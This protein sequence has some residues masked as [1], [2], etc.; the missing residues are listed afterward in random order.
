MQPEKIGSSRV[1]K[2]EPEVN[3]GLEDISV[4]RTDRKNG[5]PSVSSEQVIPPEQPFKVASADNVI[6]NGNEDQ[7]ITQIEKGIDFIELAGNLVPKTIDQLAK[8]LVAVEQWN[9]KIEKAESFEEAI[10][11]IAQTPP[12]LFHQIVMDPFQTIG[13]TIMEIEDMPLAK[14]AMPLTITRNALSVIKMVG[15]GAVLIAKKRLWNEA[16]DQL[17]KF[18]LELSKFPNNEDLKNNIKKLKILISTLEDEMKEKAV[19]FLESYASISLKTA[20]LLTSALTSLAPIVKTSLGWVVSTLDI[21]SESI[22]LWRA[23]KAKTSHE[24][25]MQE[26]KKNPRDYQ[27]AVLLLAARQQRMIFRKI[28]SYSFEDLKQHLAN[29]GVDLLAKKVTSLDEFKIRL[30]D[31]SFRGEVASFLIDEKEETIN[32]MTR[33][34]IQT[35]SEAK[36]KNERKFFDFSLIR[37]KIGVSLATIS[38]VLTVALEVLLITGAVAMAASMVFLPGIG[39]LAAGFLLGGIGLFLFY[40][41]RPNLF[42]CFIRAVNLKIALF[43]IPAQIRAME[44]RRRTKTLHKLVDKSVRYEQLAGLLEKD[45]ALNKLNP[46]VKL[47]KSLEKLRK[48][49]REKIDDFDRMGIQKQI[50]EMQTQL[51][52]KI[53]KNMNSIVEAKTRQEIIDKKLA[54]WT[55]KEGKITKLQKR[56]KEAGS[57]DFAIANRLL[58]K[59]SK[60]TVPALLLKGILDGKGYLDEETT[61]IL[62]DQFGLDISKISQDST[63]EEKAKIIDDLENF[64]KMDDSEVLSFMKQRLKEIKAS[65]TEG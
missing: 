53:D 32:V 5:L 24:T 33:N 27:D 55:G 47:Q 45:K 44:L 46:P 56:L 15:D 64:F 7:A 57:K 8:E 38:V 60:E 20:T 63:K 18:Q 52:V 6:Q 41:Y 3:A 58:E 13:P 2:V 43:S 48:Q 23:Q 1:S 26:I 25:W 12:N 65:K 22:G 10:M 11:S 30:G 51:A 29:N 37:S 54:Y 35:L 16:K 42:K 59:D 4:K 31:P 62:K 34:A 36:I 9:E 14:V 61:K 39:Y 28:E 21:L 50:E 49:T 17:E 19:S 40:K